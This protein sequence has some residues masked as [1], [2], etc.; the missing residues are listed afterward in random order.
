MKRG[1]AGKY[2]FDSIGGLSHHGPRAAPAAYESCVFPTSW[3]SQ[4]RTAAFFRSVL[5][6]VQVLLRNVVLRHLP[7]LDAALLGAGRVLHAADYSGLERLTLF[8]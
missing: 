4:R 3:R 2:P 7:R 5:V 8:D 6:L 1:R